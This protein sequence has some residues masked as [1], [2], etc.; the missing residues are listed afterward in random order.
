M[1]TIRPITIS[2]HLWFPEGNMCETF[3]AVDRARILPHNRDSQTPVRESITVK[4]MVDLRRDCA[5]G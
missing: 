5:E 4:E 1:F 2:F 3:F